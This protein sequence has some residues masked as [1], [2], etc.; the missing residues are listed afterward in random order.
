MPHRSDVA[1][2]LASAVAKLAFGVPSVT[3]NWPPPLIPSMA[4]LICSHVM[5]G[6]LNLDLDARAGHAGHQSCRGPTTP[7]S[8]RKYRDAVCGRTGECFQLVGRDRDVEFWPGRFRSWPPHRWD[9]VEIEIAVSAGDELA[10]ELPRDMVKC[11]DHQAGADFLWVLIG[12]V[13]LANVDDPVRGPNT[14][15]SSMTSLSS[16]VITPSPLTSCSGGSSR[17]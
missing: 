7:V 14:P 12:R 16:S 13:D 11:L 6:V 9:Q 4:A 17:K 8:A 15:M 10:D 2:M 1:T 5:F 3:S